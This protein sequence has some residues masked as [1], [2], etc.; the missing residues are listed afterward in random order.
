VRRDGHDFGRRVG[1]VLR[2]GAGGGDAVADDGGAEKGLAAE[3]EGAIG[4]GDVGT[5]DHALAWVE[6]GDV[7]ADAGDGADWFVAWDEGVL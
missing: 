4:A 2:E 7:A 6:A 3:A 5:A 1:G